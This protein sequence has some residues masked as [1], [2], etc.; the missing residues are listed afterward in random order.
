MSG[1]SR[2]PQ[3][4]KGA[5]VGLDPYNPLASIVIFQYNPDQLTRTLTPSTSGGSAGAGAQQQRSEPFRLAGP[6]RES[7]SVVIEVDAVDQ[8][9]EGNGSTGVHPALAALEMLIY[10]KSALMIANAVLAAAGVI[11]VIA[12]EAPLTLF[13]WGIKRV[14]PVRVTQMT[15]T[16]Q[17]FDP[18]L[19]PIRASVTLQLQVL[20]YQDLGLASVGGGIYLAHQVIKEVL[21]TTHGVGNLSAA[22]SVIAPGG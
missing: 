18:Q 20:S 9:A 5:L 11:D 1:Y 19:N 22:G 7:I 15:I 8:L 2:S 21:A 14:V 13:V 12:P 16:E 17:A 6:P 4:L 3:L 10:P